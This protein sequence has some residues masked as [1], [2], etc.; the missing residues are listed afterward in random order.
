MFCYTFLGE[1]RGFDGVVNNLLLLTLR[2][3]CADGDRLYVHQ[4]SLHSVMG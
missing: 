2:R 4:V 3:P 1:A